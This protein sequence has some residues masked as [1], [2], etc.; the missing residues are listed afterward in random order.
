MSNLVYMDSSDYPFLGLCIK[1]ENTRGPAPGES[2]MY[3]SHGG[4]IN[5]YSGSSLWVIKECDFAI[6]YLE[7]KGYKAAERDRPPKEGFSHYSSASA[8]DVLEKE[9]PESE[10]YRKLLTY[11]TEPLISKIWGKLDEYSKRS[12]SLG[13]FRRMADACAQKFSAYFTDGKKFLSTNDG[14]YSI[15][16][17]ASLLGFDY[18]KEVTDLLVSKG[19]Y[20][21]D[22]M[23]PNHFIE[24]L[25]H[26]PLEYFQEILIN[27]SDKKQSVTR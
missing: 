8:T 19:L 4:V 1:I 6:K 22:D 24:A 17:Y 12:D 10:K 27:V 7:A 9:G 15:L 25:G 21:A 2:G 18:F 5:F 26:I 11:F 3:F 13:E 14:R 23:D 16:S 20:R